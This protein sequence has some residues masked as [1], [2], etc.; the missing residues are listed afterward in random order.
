MQP[1]D[2]SRPRR[3][4]GG[5]PPVV[6][7][8]DDGEEARPESRHAGHSSSVLTSYAQGTGRKLG[9][10][11]AV[12]AILLV[13]AFLVVHHIRARDQAT[14]A[15]MTAES[16]GAAP[17]VD[18]VTIQP[19]PSTEVLGL[20]GEA[21]AWFQT[22][23]YARVNGYVANWFVDIGDRV[24]QGQVLAKID[25]PDLDQQLVAAKAQLRASDAD[26][27]VKEAEATFAKSTYE[28]WRD[29]PKGVVSDQEREAK[30][31][32]YES[33]VAYLNAAQARV[34]L[35]K[36]KVDGL[37]ALT[38]FKDVTAP[39]DGI[40]T[41]RRVDIGDLV[42]AGSTSSTTSLYAIAQSDQIR[43]FV[44]V[45]QSAGV[46]LRQGTV[47]KVTTNEYAD[48]TF[49]G[50]VTRTSESLDPH[51]RT[52]RVEV[53]LS[54]TDGALLP[55]M[56]VQVGFDIPTRPLLRVPASAL[57]FRSSGP[58]VAVVDDEGKIN[59]HP[60]TIVHDNG[61]FVEVG[62]GLAQ[63]DKAV[64]N[65]SSQIADGEKVNATNLDKTTSATPSPSDALAASKSQ[66]R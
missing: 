42:T 64:L 29:S 2:H 39:F 52:M 48:R 49:Q 59:F 5:P 45:P 41:E 26:V 65:I 11:G 20:P 18:V 3:N 40:I 22:T 25:T 16:M 28:R 23:I 19:A 61:E 12:L 63:G 47:A 9:I 21:R 43:V 50:K 44:D 56:Y 1:P 24:R 33:G 35:D 51:A 8:F 37:T 31:A 4:R 66:S 38:Q 32:A 55:G 58:Q 53:D 17:P 57:L 13:V 36:A 60:V 30:K 54:N 7:V 27:K 10:S 34:N 15:S 6:D 46:G 14:L 62:S